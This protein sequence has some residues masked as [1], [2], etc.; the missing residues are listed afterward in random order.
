MN[1]RELLR[2]SAALMG[3]AAILFGPGIVILMLGRR[4]QL[5]MSEEICLGCGY[6]LRGLPEA[7]CPE[8]G[9]LFARPHAL[10]TK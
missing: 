9:R 1:R 3:G 8:C 10:E 2:G 5:L 7:R 6:D 4:R